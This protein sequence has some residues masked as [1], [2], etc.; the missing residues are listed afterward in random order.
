MFFHRE[1]GRGGAF[2]AAA[3]LEIRCELV[4]R[5]L[6]RKKINWCIRIRECESPG[7]F[8]YEDSCHDATPGT[9]RKFSFT[10]GRNQG[11]FT[12]GQ[13]DMS[14]KVF[15]LVQKVQHLLPKGYPPCCLGL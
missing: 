10:P 5:C 2:H 15:D 7:D 4:R 6:N 13:H 9:K 12:R 1:V 14:P 8:S 3:G 11:P